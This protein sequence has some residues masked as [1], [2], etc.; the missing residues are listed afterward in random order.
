M[1]HLED[2]NEG[3]HPLANDTVVA[4]AW[5]QSG[6]AHYSGVSRTLEACQA[7][8]VKAVEQAISDFS[9][10][11]IAAQI[12]ELLRRGMA[13]IYDLDLMGQAVSPTSTTYTLR[14]VLAGWMTASSWAINWR[15]CL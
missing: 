14:R 1:E 5:G 15:G 9:R 2:L 8:T 7:H 11:F 3:P 10:P 6:F 12:D 4:Q 13:I